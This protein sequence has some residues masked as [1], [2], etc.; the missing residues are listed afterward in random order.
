MLEAQYSL[1]KNN[2]HHRNYTNYTNY[3]LWKLHVLTHIQTLKDDVTYTK[4]R[5]FKRKQK[6][7]FN[8]FE[9]LNLV[10]HTNALT[11]TNAVPTAV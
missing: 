2:K 6:G 5:K 9:V 8:A 4:Q 1:N 7:K 11:L 3:T 10:L